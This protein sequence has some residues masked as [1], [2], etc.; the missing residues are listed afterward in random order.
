LPGFLLGFPFRRWLSQPAPAESRPCG[1][2]VPSFSQAKTE[3]WL[4]ASA[5][6]AMLF[7]NIGARNGTPRPGP[8]HD[9][10]RDSETALFAKEGPRWLNSPP[11][12]EHIFPAEPAC[13]FWPSRGE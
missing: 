8:A 4:A 6:I 7:C 1:L 9:A 13:E 3:E 10:A 5:A 11:T 12:M 2:D